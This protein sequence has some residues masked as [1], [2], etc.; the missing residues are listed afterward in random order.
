MHWFVRRVHLTALAYLH[1]VGLTGIHLDSYD[2]RMFHSSILLSRVFSLGY[3]LPS[4]RSR[5]L[6]SLRRLDSSAS[7]ASFRLLGLQAFA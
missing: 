4:L 7:W 5:D 2:L 1:T 3:G 6:A